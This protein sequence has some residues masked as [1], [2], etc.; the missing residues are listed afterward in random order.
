MVREL[1]L[2]GYTGQIAEGFQVPDL[3]RAVARLIDP[4]AATRTLHWGRNYLY[5]TRCETASGPIDVVV[6]QFRNGGLRARWRRRLGGSKAARSWRVAQAMSAAGIATPEPLLLIESRC[7]GGPSFY[8][9]RY[10][11]GGVDARSP[12]RA[13]NERPLA[14]R[15]P[16]RV[17]PC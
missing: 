16:C 1:S 10:V 11:T 6:K 17:P 15:F 7:P 9:C 3:E 13:A 4:G 12:L 5:L 2:T 14:A 8:V